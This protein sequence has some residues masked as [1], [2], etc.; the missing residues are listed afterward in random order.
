[1][2]GLSGGEIFRGELLFEAT[3]NERSYFTFVRFLQIAQLH[4]DQEQEDADRQILNQEILSEVPL[5]HSSQGRQN[6]L[7]GVAEG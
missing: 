3:Y 4:H 1:L 7:M 2:R 6:F 5:A